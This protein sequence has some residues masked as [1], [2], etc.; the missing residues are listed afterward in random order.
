MND[1]SVLNKYSIFDNVPIGICIIDKDYKVLFWNTHLEDWTKIN[2]NDIIGNSLF[3]YYPNFNRFIYRSRIDSIFGGGPPV[4][5]SPQFHKELFY[6]IASS[7]EKKVFYITINSGPGIDE[8]TKTAVFSVKDVTELAM[9]IKSYKVMRDQALEEVEQRR[10]A[11]RSLMESEKQL[12]ELVATKD[13]FFSII[14]HDIKNPLSIFLNISELLISMFDSLNKEEI[15]SFI[16]DINTS[17]KNLYN[18]LENLLNWSRIQT[19][20]IVHQPNIFYI[21]VLIENVFNVLEMSFKQKNI[22]FELNIPPTEI[23]FVDADM[24]STVIR[25]LISNA[26]KFTYPNGKIVVYS[27]DL[28]NFVKISVKDNGTGMSEE[29]VSRLFRIDSHQ[30][31][32][33]TN[34][35]R[36]TGLGLILCKEFIE[37]NNG[38]ITV[39]SELEKGSNFSIIL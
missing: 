1:N 39:E 4:I 34:E 29:E 24:F 17:A 35:E 12:K 2:K 21:N 5:F 7:D 16:N 22:S 19:G 32:R 30:S 27:E 13:K 23:A 25:N 8:E 36:G 9:R 26:I 28:I 20:R 6:S 3:T 31:K 33:G 38:K 10:V 37:K 15:L 11:E 14:A 18:L